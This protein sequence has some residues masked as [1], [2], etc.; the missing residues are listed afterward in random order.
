MP[1]GRL[2]AH[3]AVVSQANNPCDRLQE[4]T[5]WG[6]RSYVKDFEHNKEEVFAVVSLCCVRAIAGWQ[7][8]YLDRVHIASGSEHSE[9][10]LVSPIGAFS[11]DEEETLCK[12]TFHAFL[13]VL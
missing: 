10:L 2:H 3:P 1:S 4:L 8:A 6:R 7:I 9:A 12:H 13:D 5:V 11:A